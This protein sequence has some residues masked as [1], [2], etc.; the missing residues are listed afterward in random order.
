VSKITIKAIPVGALSALKPATVA[1]AFGLLALCTLTYGLLAKTLGLYWDD[2]PSLW[3]LHFFSPQIFPQAFAIDRPVQGWLFVLTTSIIG[4]S[5]FAWQIFGL[6]T[7]WLTG[8]TLWWVLWSLWPRR[9]P[10]ALAVVILFLLYPGF[11]QQYIPITYGHQFLVMS[12]FFIS[13]GVMIWSIR[14]IQSS[15][16]KWYWLFSGFSLVV[17]LLSMFALEYFFGLELLRPVLL[18]IVIGETIRQPGKRLVET[19]RRWLPY[20]GMNA[21]FLVWRLTHSTPRGEVTLFKNLAENPS[22]ALWDLVQKIGVDIYESAV[23]AWGRI[24]S[25]LNTTDVKQSVILGYTAVGIAAALLAAV[26]LLVIRANSDPSTKGSLW[27]REAGS[28]RWGVTAT[29]VGLYGLLVGG[30]PIWATDL[31]LELSMPWDRFTQ[32]MMIGSSLVLV[33]LFELL[34]RPRLLKIIL[35]SVLV[36]FAA[37]FHFQ[38]VFRYRQ[39]WIEQRNFF[40]QLAWRAPAIEPGTAL[41][42]TGM[43]FYA[44]TDNSLSAGINWLYAPEL[45]SGANAEAD[46][47]QMPYMIFDINARIGNSLPSLDPDVPLFEEYRV[48]HFEGNTSQALVFYYHPP[49]CLKILDLVTDRHYPNKPPYVV[50]AMPLSRLGLINETSDASTTMPAFLGPEPKHQWCYYFEK[51]EMAVQLGQWEKAARLSEQ[52]L[53]V[54][55]ELS[56]DNAPELI[57]LIYAFAH[58]GNYDKAT[59]LSRQAAML[60]K[61]MHYYTCDTWYYLNRDIQGDPQFDQVYA[62]MYQEFECD[63][64]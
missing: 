23:V 37:G 7:R 57:P 2:W 12:S 36:G 9:K 17:G 53:Q 13:L 19:I 10:Q 38:A 43:P 21:L 56:Q 48:T 41:L 29:L 64:P 62:K 20:L 4:E 54:K 50:A 6:L 58:S 31:R 28:Q 26:L 63:S 1:T 60:S 61:K 5:L 55:P 15:D 51:I 24:F 32:P 8:I 14:K 3:F 30:W 45:P 33:G 47:R 22:Q 25:L 39:E 42:T 16:R 27:S 11:S 59:E 34:I 18:W 44:S 35:I 52:A 49:R 40:W 46:A